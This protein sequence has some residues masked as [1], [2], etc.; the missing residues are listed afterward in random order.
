MKYFLRLLISP[1][2]FILIF[3]YTCYY[4]ICRTMHFIR[5]GGEFINYDKDEKVTIQMIYEQLKMK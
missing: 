3:V 5:F 2:V 4:T 1:A